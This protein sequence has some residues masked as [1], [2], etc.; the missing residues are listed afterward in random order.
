MRH[1]QRSCPGEANGA[2]HS[3]AMQSALAI[4]ERRCATT[5]VVRD[6][7]RPSS[8]RCTAASLRVS[9][10]LYRHRQVPSTPD[11]IKSDHHMAWPWQAATRQAS[12]VTWLYDVWDQQ[13]DLHC[14][15][16]RCRLGCTTNRAPVEESSFNWRHIL[17]EALLHVS[18]QTWQTEHDFP[19]SSD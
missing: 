9:S 12:C 3:P 4:V 7:M 17:Q 2:G 11:L 8:A 10:A 1:G 6:F 5:T 16:S 13:I 15:H 14:G 19:G 18:M